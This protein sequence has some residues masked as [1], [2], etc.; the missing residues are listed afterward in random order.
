ME[1]KEKNVLLVK[2]NGV[3]GAVRKYIDI[4][5]EELRELGYNTIVLDG[6]VKTFKEKHQWMIEHYPLYAVIDCQAMLQ[7]LLPKQQYE[8]TVAQ[9]HY[10]CDHPLHL[11]SRFEKLNE[12]SVILNVDRKHTEYLRKYYPKFSQVEFMPLSGVGADRLLSFEERDIEVLFT[13]SYWVPKEPAHYS[14]DMEFAD[15]VRWKVQESLLQDPYF[16]IEEALEAVLA[17]YQIT[18][19]KE[20][21]VQI[22]SELSE[23]ES[24]VRQVNRDKIIRTL[25]KAGVEVSV[26]GDGW[27]NLSCE[28]IEHLH[29]LDGGT[30][31]ARRALG[32]T[33]IALNIMPGFKA[34]F[35]ER[36]AAAMQSGAVVVT[37]TSDYLKE[38]FTDGQEL[39]FYQLERLEELPDKIKALLEDE[40][41]GKRIAQCGKEV[42]E[43]KHTWKQRVRF[44]AEQ[45]EKYHGNAFAE[46]D[47]KGTELTVPMEQL[48]T[49]YVI[50]EIGVQLSEELNFVN[51]L[52]NCGCAEYE[53]ARRLLEKLRIWNGQLE[54]L[55][56]Y[57]FYSG[58]N[59]EMFISYYEHELRTEEGFAGQMLPFLLSVDNL[60]CGVKEKYEAVGIE[61]L[62][63]GMPAGENT[64]L[65]DRLL[66]D[67]MREKYKD[68]AD[69]A[70]KI[71]QP[72]FRKGSAVYS[73]PHRLNDMY[74]DFKAD[75][76]YDSECDMMYVL[77]Q[78]KRMY[79][80]RE[81][82][83]RMVYTM[84]RFCC[85]EQDV[86]S[87]HCYLNRDFD[88]DEGAT[89]V[90]AGVAEGN[91][92]LEIIDRVK[93]I[94][95][96]ECDSRWLPA[97]ERT[98]APYRDK[99]VLVPK[100]LG[101]QN[102]D[103]YISMDA[104]TQGEKIDFIK[105]DVEGAEADALLGAKE[106]LQRNPAMKC[107]V[108]TYHAHGMGEQVK[109][110]LTE[111]GF[112]VSESAGYI[113][114]KNYNKPVWES[115]L[116]H[117]LVRAEKKGSGK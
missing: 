3:Y 41:R 60:L 78:G 61:E 75:I 7:E 100:M 10:F 81:C 44:M 74:K 2:G 95:L 107:V 20:D 54:Q 14:A 15:A 104:M 12:N 32:R 116:R 45:I 66:P 93:K 109:Q 1:K 48:R 117:A 84:Y 9:V 23:I 4:F 27:E 55:C 105:M 111:Q 72:D 31:A 112:A 26:F 113:F 51:D 77:H 6:N 46:T 114:Y 34:G 85:L 38:E 37:D 22:L 16:T 94:Y 21:F 101:N 57:H 68:S 79:F 19:S 40:A 53:D 64:K 98:F 115:E 103:G 90:D 43:K 49:S 71:W 106:T 73:Y 56:G 47:S 86:T 76:Q 50:E 99:V 110:I 36:I 58:N 102:D 33:K 13:G 70:I 92:A 62:T 67:I 89:V 91:F 59:M 69:E 52:N 28:G 83:E 39:V 108:A 65:Y 18:V 63:V 96:V 30:E 87:P 25:L 35:Q 88:V 5:T 42:A 80:P 82:S 24:Y 29:I 8:D 17:E 97:L 11:Y